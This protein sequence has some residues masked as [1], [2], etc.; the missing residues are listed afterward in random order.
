MR[1]R[2][3]VPSDRRDRLTDTERKGLD[4]LCEAIKAHGEYPPTEVSR[5]NKL[6]GGQ[7]VVHEDFWRDIYYRRRTSPADSPE[8]RKKAFQRVRDKLQMSRRI[9]ADAGYYWLLQAPGQAGQNGTPQ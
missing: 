6:S 1:H 5:R 9:Q 7:R 2:D 4:T 8:A 3:D